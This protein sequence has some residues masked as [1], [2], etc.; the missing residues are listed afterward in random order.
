MGCESWHGRL[1]TGR[2]R[3][4]A[5]MDAP[6]TG[7]VVVDA[8]YTPER[9]AFAYPGFE[10]G[11]SYLLTRNAALPLSERPGATIGASVVHGPPGARRA[12]LDSVLAAAGQAPL[13]DRHAVVA[14]GSNRN[15][16]HLAYRMRGLGSHA[17]PVLCA[18]L[19]GA[20]V[21]FPAYLGLYGVVTSTLLGEPDTVSRVH[22]LLCD[23]AQLDALHDAEG[24]GV[25][26]D[27]G[28]LESC[29][30][31][32]DT[33]ERLRRPHV[34]ACRPGVAAI[35][36]APRRLSRVPV[37]RSPIQPATLEQV[38]AW[39][40]RLGR[41]AGL[42]LRDGRDV[43]AL[44]LDGRRDELLGLMSDHARPHALAFTALNSEAEP[45]PVP[46]TSSPR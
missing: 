17:L 40:V 11:C 27:F 31:E 28:P 46:G 12:G 3:Y 19:H 18:R 5:A 8:T 24:T 16:H 20:A 7:P 1:D 45:R 9:D 38:T 13:R 36:G 41:A 33:G 6:A 39:L 23:R 14:F 42:E 35:D 30:V 25:R 34:F 29:W 37:D 15:P 43:Q 2:Q 10:V 26:H 22:L 32:L 4:G 21:V 44:C